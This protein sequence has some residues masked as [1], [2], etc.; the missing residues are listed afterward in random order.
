MGD[1][2]RCVSSYGVEM[3]GSVTGVGAAGEAAVVLVFVLEPEPFVENEKGFENF[4]DV[5]SVTDLVG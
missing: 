4:E 2:P 5:V 3:K 1:L